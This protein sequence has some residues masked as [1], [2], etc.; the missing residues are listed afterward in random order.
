MAFR[1]QINAIGQR[2]LP[3]N[4]DPLQ[5]ERPQSHRRAHLSIQVHFIARINGYQH[6]TPFFI[7]SRMNIYIDET[8][9]IY[10]LE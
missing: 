6:Y 9:A 1:L 10:P 7:S 5:D 8:H 2:A 3:E 4:V